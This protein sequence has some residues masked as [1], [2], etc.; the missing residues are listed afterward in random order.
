MA[1]E[2][3]TLPDGRTLDVR[4][5]GPSAGLPLLYHHGTPSASMPIRAF[6]RAAHS[7]GF[8]FVSI[9]R[10]GYGGSTPLPG[11]SVAD[12]VADAEVA[13][14]MAG[15]GRCLVA[16]WSGGGPHALACAARLPGVVPS[17][18]WRASLPTAPRV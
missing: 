6:E 12:V 5:S 13:L 9:S 4:I 2:Q 11:R 17:L 15:G 14:E 7:R 3:R 8:Q 10:P 16:G 18:S 1:L